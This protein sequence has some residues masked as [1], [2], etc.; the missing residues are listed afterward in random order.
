M[1]DV[2]IIKPEI[3]KERIKELIDEIKKE[4]NNS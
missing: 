3:N 4:L 1:V 2:K